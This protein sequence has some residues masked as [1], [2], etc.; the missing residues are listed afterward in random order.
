MG[1][2]LAATLASLHRIARMLEAGLTGAIAPSEGSPASHSVEVRRL[3][4]GHEDHPLGDIGCPVGHALV[5]VFFD[6]LASQLQV[7]VAQASNGLA[8][9]RGNRPSHIEDTLAKLVPFLVHE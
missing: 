2:W 6:N 7:M 9:R 8:K 4:G 3:S 1:M 5:V